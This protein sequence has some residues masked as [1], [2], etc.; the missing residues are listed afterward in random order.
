MHFRFFQVNT[1]WLVPYCVA[2]LLLI[3]I[4]GCDTLPEQTPSIS[5]PP[6]LSNF[7][8]TP[9]QLDLGTAPEGTV[10][11]GSASISFSASVDAIDPDGE[12]QQ[13]N[14]IL[15]SPTIGSDPL[16]NVEMTAAGDGT[17]AVSHTQEVPE[18]ETG[19]YTIELYAVDNTGTLSNRVLGTFTLLNVQNPPVI[20]SVEAP[21]TVTRP[22]EG[23]LSF[24]I[25]ATVSDPQGI[26]NVSTVLGWNVNSP[27]ATFGLFDDGA[28]GDDEVAGDGRFTATV[29][30]SSTN[31]PGVNTLAF[32]ATDRSGLRSEVVTIDITIE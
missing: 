17:Y 30:I 26:A 2:F 7:T 16:A 31:A 29:Q 13:V 9:R 20:E 11:N 21:D 27:A 23:T 8:Y 1:S 14:F 19:D 4:A 10:V 22:S 12:V 3:L 28:G 18:G 24:Q 5:R 15:R 25:I 6:E 32:Q